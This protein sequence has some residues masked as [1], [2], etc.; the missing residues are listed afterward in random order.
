M[1]PQPQLALAYTHAACALMAAAFQ[2]PVV[3]AMLGGGGSSVVGVGSSGF[4]GGGGA[5]SSKGGA[6]HGAHVVGAHPV[7]IESK[8]Q[9]QAS[10]SSSSSTPTDKAGQA[11]SSKITTPTEK[12]AQAATGQAPKAAAGQSSSTPH[13][14]NTSTGPAC[15]NKLVSVGSAVCGL[16]PL[17]QRPFI[18]RLFNQLYE[19]D[20]GQNLVGGPILFV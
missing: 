16:W 9:H 6:I 17:A 18:L 7:H 2:C 13:N 10:S 4:G 12:A 14:A 1:S 5:G 3:S 15:T 20:R 19:S 11:S 8:A